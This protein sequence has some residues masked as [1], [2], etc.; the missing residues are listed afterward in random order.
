MVR[1]PG[2]EKLVIA[3]TPL[4]GEGNI[5][6]TRSFTAVL[7][8]AGIPVVEFYADGPAVRLGQRYHRA[9]TMSTRKTMQYAVISDRV[10]SSFKVLPLKSALKGAVKRVSRQHP[11]AACFLTSQSMMAEASAAVLGRIPTLMASSDA[12]GKF[13]RGSRLS[14]LHRAIAYLVWNREAF[15]FYRE[16]LK[17]D[18]VYLIKPV[19]PRAAFGP[20]EREELTFRDAL[21]EPRLCYIK[22]SGSGG[23]PA[24]ISKAICSLRKRAKVRIIVFPGTAEMERKIIRNGGNN[25]KVRSSLDAAVFYHMARMIIPREQMLLTYPSEQVKHVAVLSLSG[26]YPRVVWLPPRGQHEV[27]SLAWAIKQGFPG[28]VCLPAEYH[29][30]LKGLLI[31]LGVSP[32]DVEF[33]MPENLSAEHF[34]MVPPW[35]ADREALPLEEIVSKIV[36]N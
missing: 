23:D 18:H 20:V 7:K 25:D 26:I 13:I 6:D 32:S 27:I 14:E 35:N 17:L 28:T 4:I 21:E 30:G 24:L 5:V 11:G 34:R 16:E 9:M 22:L 31:D 36:R 12:I 10:R 15:S 33:I 2:Q 3:G 1:N 8:G 29:R 19:D